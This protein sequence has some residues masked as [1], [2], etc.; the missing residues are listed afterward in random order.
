[1]DQIFDEEL[2]LYRGELIQCQSDCNDCACSL[3]GVVMSSGDE[4][5]SST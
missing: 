2:H 3:D 4:M 1:M 5:N